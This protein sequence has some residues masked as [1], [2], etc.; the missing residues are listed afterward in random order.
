MFLMASPILLMSLREQRSK[1]TSNDHWPNLYAIHLI[2]L[3][4][5]LSAASDAIWGNHAQSYGIWVESCLIIMGYIAHLCLSPH[6]CKVTFPLMV[7]LRPFY[8]LGCFQGNGVMAPWAL[9]WN[10]WCQAILSFCLLVSQNHHTV[11]YIESTD[12]LILKFNE[13]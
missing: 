13:V 8:F 10:Y 6:S 7:S 1:Y 9:G 3:P 2:T 11:S 12:A 5:S 4:K